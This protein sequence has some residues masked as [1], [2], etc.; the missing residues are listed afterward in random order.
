MCFRDVLFEPVLSDMRILKKLASTWSSGKMI[1]FV[2][3]V[4]HCC[5]ICLDVSARFSKKRHELSVMV[6]AK[7]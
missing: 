2:E 7:A 1:T 3:C 4:G 6:P 5:F